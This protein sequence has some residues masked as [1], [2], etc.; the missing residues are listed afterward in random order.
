MTKLPAQRELAHQLIDWERVESRL[1]RYPAIGR[2]FPL[3]VL[4][5]HSNSRPYYCHYMSLRLGTWEN[6][7]LFQRLEE[8]LCCA[9][10]LPNWKHEKSLLL[11]ADF[12]DFWSLVW[13]LQVAEYLCG[14]GTD[15][16]WAKSGPDL[17]VKII[18][19]KRWYVE[20]YTPRKSFGLLEYLK[21]ILEKCDP[22]V[23]AYYDLCLPFSLPQNSD[24]TQFLDEVL[25]RSLDP[26][27]LAEAKKAAETEYLVV[28]YKDPG[29]SLHI[30]VEGDNDDAYMPGITPDKNGNPKLYVE[31]ILKEAVNAKKDSNDLKNH[32]PNLLAVNCAP[33]GEGFAVAR[34]LPHR[35]Q[36]L[37]IPRID[38]NIDALAVSVVGIDERLTREKLEVRIHSK[39]AWRD[40]LDRIA[41]HTDLAS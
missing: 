20:C 10:A 19:N 33:G 9:E 23:H 34:A 7:D 22:D 35:T 2:A 27:C 38:P 13:Q 41:S 31:C 29:S 28:L 36:C 26:D 18:D 4:E 30:Y 11:S 6:E 1:M 17:S 32:H 8:L 15:V 37:N 5:K 14:V 24:R 21:E 3:A 39:S 40:S 16:C 25:S 12:A